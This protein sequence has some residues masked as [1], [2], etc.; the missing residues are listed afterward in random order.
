MRM[1]RRCENPYTCGISW[2][3]A[4]QPSS[5]STAAQEM[6]QLRT[7]VSHRLAFFQSEAV[8]LTNHSLQRIWP[9]V[10]ANDKALS[11]N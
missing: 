10:T 5:D 3:A 4:S 8:R 6:P 9:A 1:A 2:A 11:V 7:G